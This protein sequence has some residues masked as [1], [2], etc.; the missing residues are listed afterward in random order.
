MAT[1]QII[2]IGSSP[3]DGN[4]DPLRTAFQK[5]NQNFSVLFGISGITG[6]ANGTSNISIPVANSNIVMSVGNV[7]NVV[8]VVANGMSTLG[9]L[10]VSSYVN[11]GNVTSAGTILA[12]GTIQSLSAVTAVTVTA[13]GNLVGSNLNVTNQM[14]ASTLLLTGNVINAELNVSGNIVAA[15]LTSTG[16]LTVSANTA[17]AGNVTGSYFI[18]NGSQLTG[19]TAAPANIFNI[20]NTAGSP[21]IIADSPNDTLNFTFGNNIT[22][23]GNSVTD[24]LNFTFSESP[25][26]TG[27]VSAT[28]FVGDLKG[29]VFADD[30]T[31]MVDAVDNKLF[32][33][34][35]QT[36]GNVTANYF[37]GNG[38]LLTGVI[39]T[40][41][42]IS[43]GTSNVAIATSNG[44]V[45]FNVGGTADVM[46]VTP[47]TVIVNGNLQIDGELE[48]VNV[49]TVAIEDPIIGLG[50]GANNTPLTTND[51]KDRG[52]QL[53]YYGASEKSAFLGYKN[54]S[55][56]LFIANDV[57]ITN[58]LVTVNG[59]GTLEVGNLYPANITTPGTINATGNITAPYFLGNV[60]GNISGN[61]VVGGANTEV[62]F[63]DNGVANATAGFTFD[64]STN[65]A[66][67]SGNLTVGQRISLGSN[68]VI[69]DT[70]GNALAIGVGAG[71]TNQDDYAVAI[72]F[73]C[74][75]TDQGEASVAVGDRAG[76]TSQGQ[77]SVAI[78]Y[79][80]ANTGQ[81]TE[82]V[83][84]GYQA[85]QSGQGNSAVAIGSYAGALSSQGDY[86]VAM[87]SDAG[88]S[89]QGDN[90]IAIGYNAGAL[91]QGGL[92][93]CIGLGA[94]ANNTPN[95]AIVLN[96]SGS[97]LDVSNSYAFYVDPVRNDTSN[98]SEIVFY[99]AT[100]KEI[101]Y[102][103]TI[104]ID[105]NITTDGT[106]IINSGN[107]QTA[108]NNGGAN[109]VGNIGSSS[110]YFN[111]VFAQSTSALY[112]DLA[113]NYQADQ[114][115]DA[116]TVLSFG[117]VNEVTQSS[118]YSDQRVVGVVSS[119][120]AYTMN[121]GLQGDH[122]VTIALVGRVPCKVT[123]VIERGDML[124]SAGNG[125]A[126]ACATPAMGTVIGKAIED[127]TGGD[128]MVEIVVG[129]I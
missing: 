128:G 110:K 63:N 67:I 44:N 98:V 83:A 65:A 115:Y 91:N 77:Y 33:S 32:A 25:T 31:L 69:K 56:N 103:N 21:L 19:V 106:L 13:S 34:E 5:T 28:T 68:V 107:A 78:G 54:S 82:A 125:M 116:G 87:G 95:G 52:T 100:T 4:G 64:K 120:P 122:V 6:I 46:V 36:T 93:I 123:G 43:N 104:N 102:G 37:L 129:R 39:T 18:G 105:G 16:P 50:R 49:T 23:T 35:L 90:S 114:S 2:N 58:E 99:N 42:N 112:A 84:I 113:E 51:G 60:L 71:T 24:T 97:N 70:A 22:I 86:A 74:G 48:Y 20:I 92:S 119:R 53:W 17:I 108:I 9:N 75:Q 85:G 8:T 72:G 126:C 118:I 15:A 14:R 109:A 89:N 80:T 94:G 55:G 121:S 12:N 27:T 47:Q 40:V 66:S 10:S 59:F 45:S 3:N 41:S 38:A 76:Q 26:F 29:S 96:G 57:T 111:T 88:R 124:I 127:F 62:V 73:E 117:G 81:G 61:L 79:D 7:A 30:S 11:A 101:T 1:Q